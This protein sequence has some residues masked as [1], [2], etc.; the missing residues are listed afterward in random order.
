MRV[1]RISQF[2]EIGEDRLEEFYSKGYQKRYFFPHR[3][4]YLPKC[5]P[6][7]F[8]LAKRMFGPCQLEQLWQIIIYAG[9]SITVEFPQELFFDEDLI[10]HQQ[11]FGKA[12]QV[13]TANLIARGRSLYTMCH[14][15][16]LV[17]RMSRRR[18]Y[19]TRIQKRFKGWNHMLLNGI[20]NFAREN[21]FDRVFTPTSELALQNTD[22]ARNV[23]RALFDRTYDSYLHQLFK[24]SRQD[25]WWAIDVKENQGRVITP[26]S[27]SEEIPN[28][29]TICLC[30]D[31]ERGYGH[32]DVDSALAK[33]AHETSGRHLDEM[34][35][36]EGEAGVKATYNVLGLILPE[37]RKQIE[38]NGHC[39]AFHSYDHQ[40]ERDETLSNRLIKFLNLRL[41]RKGASPH[42]AGLGQLDKC[43]LIDYRI[44]GYRPP[45]SKITPALS[46]Q[47]LAF[48]NFEWFASSAY[49]LRMKSP[50][51]RNRIVKVPILFDDF[52]LYGGNMKYADWEEKAIK[53]IAGSIKTSGFVAFSLHDCYAH[54]W[55]PHYRGFL[56]KIRGL[57]RLK[58]LD[59]VAGE[60]ILGSA[61]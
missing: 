39:L 17:Q 52:K 16:D 11:H 21:N 53:M 19:K 37:V 4:Y 45:Q 41:R 18:E 40:V 38:S 8:K 3:I 57:G 32:T 61:K 36:I 60:V 15:S 50:A 51:M 26:A 24:A 46:D 28:E 35:A 54:L 1:M 12:G 25:G 42:D 5:G 49:S 10:W 59:E 9:Q 43:R 58:T 23:G 2:R 55:L 47:K 6:D 29:E 34:L 27:K 14:H 13:A 33:S 56:E 20:L 48:H 22:R 30:H 7:G 31:I 44:K